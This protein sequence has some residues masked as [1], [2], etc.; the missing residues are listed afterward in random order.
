[1]FIRYETALGDSGHADFLVQGL[2][3]VFIVRRSV[4]SVLVLG[5]GFE[6]H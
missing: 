5:F 3:Q 1:M 6:F 2:T 4:Q